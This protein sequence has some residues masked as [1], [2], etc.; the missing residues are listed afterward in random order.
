M[1]RNHQEH[2]Y[3]KR[4]RTLRRLHWVLGHVRAT[5][6][7][8]IRSKPGKLAPSL[9]SFQDFV[10]PLRTANRIEPRSLLVQ[11]LPD[12]SHEILQCF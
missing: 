11:I 12:G 5:L 4:I 7:H 2:T 3:G 10:F 1:S 8:E 6:V 9:G